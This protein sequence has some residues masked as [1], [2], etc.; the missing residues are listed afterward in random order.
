MVVQLDKPRMSRRVRALYLS[1][2]KGVG[3]KYYWHWSWGINSKKIGPGNKVYGSMNDD[4]KNARAAFLFYKM[5][6]GYDG[7]DFY[8]LQNIVC[9]H[10]IAATIYEW[11][12]E[13]PN[14]NIKKC[15]KAIMERGTPSEMRLFAMN[16]SGSH[17]DSLNSLATVAE[18]FSM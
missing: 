2:F 16:I 1:I 15:Q 12:R 5:Y 11:A 13:I 4:Q 18:V 9:K 3:Y 17:S 6:G 10:G 8:K 7:V 14:A